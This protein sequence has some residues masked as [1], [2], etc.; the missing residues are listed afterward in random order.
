MPQTGNL[1]LV[2]FSLKM[3]WAI[4][5]RLQVRMVIK[6]LTR[7]VKGNYETDTD[8]LGEYTLASLT[9]NI[10]IRLIKPVNIK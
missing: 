5:Y 10:F 1:L 6:W 7:Y 8:S 2:L 3:L 9:G 4:N